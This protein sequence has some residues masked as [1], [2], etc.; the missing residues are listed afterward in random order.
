MSGVNFF[1]GLRQI[2]VHPGVGLAE[3]P[4]SIIMVGTV[5]RSGCDRDELA[6]AIV[7]EARALPAW[8]HDRSP[9]NVSMYRRMAT[10][11][12]AAVW[13]PVT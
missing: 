1:R 6:E 13:P 4:R 3:L 5:A 10:A 9:Q 8:A 7:V 12:S 2:P 11:C